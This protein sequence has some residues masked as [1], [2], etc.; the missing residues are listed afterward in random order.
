M[1][2]YICDKCGKVESGDF[3]V[4][5]DDNFYCTECD[6][7]NQKEREKEDELNRIAWLAR[8]PNWDT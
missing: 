1:I 7:E 5:I 8:H 6:D 3:M 4:R 2:H